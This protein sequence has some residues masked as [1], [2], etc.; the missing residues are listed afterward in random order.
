MHA[1]GVRTFLEVGPGNKLTGLINAILGEKDHWAFALDASSGKQSGCYDL[2]RTL[3]ALA[4]SGHVVDLSQWD[5][6]SSK[7]SRPKP[8]LTVPIC[9]ANYVKSRNEGA[10]EGRSKMEGKRSETNKGRKN[11]PT[12]DANP[13]PSVREN[14]TP[15]VAKPA[16]SARTS[17]STP[18]KDLP[19]RSSPDD[20]AFMQALRTTQ[21]NLSAVQR[22]SE[23]T[24][25]AHRQFLEGQ[26]KALQVFRDLLQQQQKLF[27]ADL[28]SPLRDSE[29]VQTRTPPT[30]PSSPDA[31]TIVPPELPADQPIVGPKEPTTAPPTGPDVSPLKNVLL[32]VVAEKTGYPAEML[33]WEMELDSDLG[34][35]SIKRVEI[36][37]AL[38]ER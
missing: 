33:D 3:A 21:E 17:Q 13:Q 29:K 11:V 28:A 25:Q 22:L 1:S 34:I 31:G 2:A 23:Q 16:F 18:Q 4:A 5:P 38:Q 24:A 7:P 32:E 37:S 15:T 30:R 35:D 12:N 8:G 19:G 9:G 10:A 27:S 36:F 14:S 6:D 20:P 26:D